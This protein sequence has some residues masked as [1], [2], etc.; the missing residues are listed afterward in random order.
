M[1]VVASGV[2]GNPCIPE[3][4]GI[5]GNQRV[6]HSRNYKG[7]EAYRGKK[8]LIVGAGNSGAELTVELS[9]IADV[10]LISKDRL[11]F[12]SLTKDLSNIRGLS[13]SLLKELINFKIVSLKERVEPKSISGGLVTLSD[14]KEDEFD[15]I[16]LA[17]GYC[18]HLPR[19]T[20]M[21]VKVTNDGYPEL[22][23]LCESV[24]VEGLYFAGPL[25]V[26]SRLCSFIHCFRPAV[27][28]MALGIAE[29]LG[30]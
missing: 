14:G 17:T 22:T 8:V 24:S 9:G 3:I 27:E 16:I 6:V 18:P 25:A 30:R 12:Y 10:T 11:K 7:L 21:D 5:D 23:S 26:S 4:D 15:E 20:N 13:E 28:P 29:K 2:I 19:F 1:V